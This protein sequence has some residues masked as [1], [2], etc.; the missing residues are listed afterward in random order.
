ME[1]GET[2]K[3]GKVCNLSVAGGA[4]PGMRQGYGEKDGEAVDRHQASE[5]TMAAQE[6]KGDIARPGIR[7]EK[8]PIALPLG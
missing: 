8:P 4:C 3:S 7:L 2:G 5:V 6:H 1:D